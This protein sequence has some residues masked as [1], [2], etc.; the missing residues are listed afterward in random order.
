MFFIA[1]PYLYAFTAGNDQVVFGGFLLN[2]LDGN[3][4]L[5]KMRQGWEGAW[6]FR[7]P[8]TVEPGKGGY[9]NIFYILLGHL[10]RVVHLPLLLTFHLVRWLSAGILLSALWHFYGRI[11]QQASSRRLAYALAALGSGMGWLLIP[12]GQ[13]T[14]D[15]W[16]A[17]AYP[18]LSASTNPHFTLGLALMLWLIVP[19]RKRCFWRSFLGSVGLALVLS[20]ISPFG[21]AIAL[22]ILSI[23]WLW[24][25]IQLLRAGQGI[26]FPV[27]IA[28]IL[29]GGLPFLI[30]DLWLVHNDPV[31]AVWNAQNLTSSP[32][33]WDV[34]ISLSPALPFSVLTLWKS[35]KKATAPTMLL[36]WLIVGIILMYVPWNLQRRFM[37]GL[38]IPIA[39]LAAWSLAQKR[40]SSERGYHFRV[41]GLFTLALPTNLI[42]IMITVFGIKTFDEQ[43]YLTQSEERALHWLDE[44]TAPDALIL[45][46]PEMGLWIPARTGRRVIYGHPYETTN[47]KQEEQAVRDFFAG[48]MSLE[49]M[50]G[51]IVTRDVDYIFSGPREE[52]LGEV[53]LPATVLPVYISDDVVIYQIGISKP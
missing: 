3:T 4:Y 38:Y 23:H 16:V 12:I 43:I 46:G 25:T 20:I 45:S 27:S 1:V 2:P 49:E 44:Q 37:M 7:L 31:F 47:A 34:L 39:G 17:E 51:F 33:W 29:L 21:I 10:A 24:Q 30:Y 53:A 32:V 36:I 14:A 19:G 42:I 15:F 6:R 48:M 50:E 52:T 5:A 8:Y 18:F 28:A 41:L 40:S 35:K 11:F 9:L 13:F 26:A 22:I